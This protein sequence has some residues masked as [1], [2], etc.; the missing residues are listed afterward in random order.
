M[1]DSGV[2][3]ARRALV[4]ALPPSHSLTSSWPGQGSQALVLKMDP[5]CALLGHRLKNLTWRFWWVSLGGLSRGEGWLQEDLMPFHMVRALQT[6]SSFRAPPCC[7]GWRQYRG[8]L[9]GVLLE[10]VGLCSSARFAGS[11]SVPVCLDLRVCQSWGNTP[12]E[13]PQN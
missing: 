6:R 10:S 12:Q 13:L 4:V 8:G 3:D 1:S 7:S 2:S 9:P 11:V 5:I